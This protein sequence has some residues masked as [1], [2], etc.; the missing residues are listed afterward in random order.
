MTGCSNYRESGS[1]FATTEAEAE[2]RLR[3]QERRIDGGLAPPVVPL[4]LDTQLGFW[5]GELLLTLQAALHHLTH[6][7]WQ[8]DKAV[9]GCIPAGCH[10]E[11]SGRK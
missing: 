2:L 3:L 10:R 1:V 11:R 7:L 9:C 8:L 5:T 4:G 6:S